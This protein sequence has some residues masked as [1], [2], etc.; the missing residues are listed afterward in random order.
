MKS[1]GRSP[2]CGEEPAGSIFLPEDL[3]AHLVV[4]LLALLDDDALGQLLSSEADRG[5]SDLLAVH[6][7]TALHDETAGLTVGS[8][9]TSLDHQGQDADGAVGQVSLGQLSVGHML[10]I[11]GSTAEQGAG[12][13][14]R[15]VG[16]LFAVDH[17]GQ[18]EGKD[19]PWPR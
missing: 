10:S 17:L 4:D 1:P 12:C 15:L 14:L 11:T 13:I 18:L 6:Q 3:Q 16:L 9:Q 2:S 5:S 8:S 19:L 7:N